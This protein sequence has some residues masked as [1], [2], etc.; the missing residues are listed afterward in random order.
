MFRRALL[1]LALL[2]L[3][4]PALAC[5]GG[6]DC[7][8]GQKGGPA[9]DK[10]PEMGRGRGPGG[11]GHGRLMH[12]T[13]PLPNFMRVVVHQG[14][15]LKLT[16]AQNKAFAEWRATAHQRSMDLAQGI[17]LAEQKLAEA[18]RAGDD[19]QALALRYE[20][21]AKKRRELFDLKAECRAL[22]KRE[23]SAEQWATLVKLE[24]EMPGPGK[25]PMGKGPMGQ[26]QMGQGPGP[27][28]GKPCAGKAKGDKPCD[29]DK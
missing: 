7:D 2:G 27:N 29:C 23:L 17:V 3:S 9:A 26:G 16:D 8:C 1:T 28:G 15:E 5:P 11:G 22:L 20:E 4:A 25:G 13:N 24:G 10:G 6:G 21:I 18:A 19:T 12:H 14:A